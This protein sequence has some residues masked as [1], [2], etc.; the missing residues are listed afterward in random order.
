M[1]KI[2]LFFEKYQQQVGIEQNPEDFDPDEILDSLENDDC[3][4]KIELPHSVK[5]NTFSR[6]VTGLYNQYYS[7]KLVTQYDYRQRIKT[8][9]SMFADDLVAIPV[10]SMDAYNQAQLKDYELMLKLFPDNE[11]IQSKM[12]ELRKDS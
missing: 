2:A 6:L 11:L 7:L 10:V 9:P 8:H 3:T 12:Q 4:E 1:S 5:S